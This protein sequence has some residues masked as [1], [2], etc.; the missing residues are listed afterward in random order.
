MATLYLKRP[1]SLMFKR[2]FLLIYG[3]LMMSIVNWIYPQ[4]IKGDYFWWLHKYF[5]VISYVSRRA[6]C[7][8]KL[9]SLFVEMLNKILIY[10]WYFLQEPK[11]SISPKECLSGFG[12]FE[13]ICQ[14][15]YFLTLY[16]TT[17]RLS[18]ARG[19]ITVGR[20]PRT[21]KLPP[22]PLWRVYTKISLKILIEISFG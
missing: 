1:T 18:I 16:F 9:S 12:T 3:M 15:R 7:F 19:G 17:F 10:C 22:S 13:Q 20:L 11:K 14:T 5:R 6:W 4:V 2:R 8:C 21:L